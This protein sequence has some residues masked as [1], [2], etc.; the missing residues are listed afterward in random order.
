LGKT[1]GIKTRCYWEQPWGANWEQKYI[2]NLM[3]THWER[4]K[5][6]KGLPS[7]KLK[8]KINQ[9]SG[10]LDSFEKNESEIHHCKII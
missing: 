2:G 4:R 10:F 9:G 6:E 1:Y 7:P 8:R 5:N 3:G